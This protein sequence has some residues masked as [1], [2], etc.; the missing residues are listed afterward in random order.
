L[1]LSLFNLTFSLESTRL[2]TQGKAMPYASARLAHKRPRCNLT[3]LARI[4]GP[5]WF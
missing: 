2:T 3:V 5:S 1:I 4:G